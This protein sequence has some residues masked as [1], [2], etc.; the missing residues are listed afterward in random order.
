MPIPFSVNPLPTPFPP[1]PHLQETHLF[2]P[3]LSSCCLTLQSHAYSF[4][5]YQ[6]CPLEVPSLLHAQSL[7]SFLL[8][9]WF[10][11]SSSKTSSMTNYWSYS[12]SQSLAA[13]MAFSWPSPHYL[14]KC[15]LVIICPFACCQL[16]LFHRFVA[17]SRKIIL[18]QYL[19]QHHWLKIFT[20]Y[21]NKKLLLKPLNNIPLELKHLS[22][23]LLL[24]LSLSKMKKSWFTLWMVSLLPLI[25]FEPPISLEEFHTSLIVEESTIAK[26]STVE[27]I[28]T[29]MAAF[30]PS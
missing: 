15:Y 4:G 26:N 3:P 22:T 10:P 24:H 23:S 9:R 29:T 16:S 30:H 8:Y 7:F 17:F 14:N 11:S 18:L 13:P 5:L 2:R 1:N 19:I 20:L 12:Y 28:P 27:T 25:L 21:H 6:L